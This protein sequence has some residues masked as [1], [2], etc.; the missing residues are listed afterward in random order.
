MDYP[1][2][3]RKEQVEHIVTTIKDWSIAH[4]L[5]VRPS[6]AFVPQDSDPENVLAVTAPVTLFPSI[7]PKACF[8]EALQVQTAYN[9]LYALISTDEKWLGDIVN[10]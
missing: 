9:K 8:E 10:E 6:P 4:G 7:L 1:P 5:A 3:L 2:D